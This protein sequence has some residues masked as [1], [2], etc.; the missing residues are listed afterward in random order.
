[1]MGKYE[2]ELPEMQTPD[3]LM[4]QTIALLDN[5]LEYKEMM[6][7]YSCALK[8]VH[9]K[10]EVLD[11]EFHVKYKRNPIN[12]IQTRLKS[13]TSII[14]KAA[15]LGIAPTVENIEG[16]INDIAGIRVICPYIDD[17]YKLSSAL[18][19]Q[20]DIELIRMRDYISRP[21]PNGYRSLHLLVSV[22]VCFADNEKKI[23]VEVQIRTIAMDFW[24]SLEHQIKYKQDVEEGNTVVTR[25]KEC[26]DRIAETDSMMQDIRIEMDKIKEKPSGEAA[27]YEK[28]KR[29]DIPL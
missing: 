2:L 19:K 26:A 24:A 29:I 25:L 22:P 13:Q 9:T 10:L 12:A 23:R 1:M 20:R 27:I 15:R 17:I 18:T 3:F 11:T 8:E 28:L 6:M 14:E 4:T 7:N 5:I 16:H 21:K